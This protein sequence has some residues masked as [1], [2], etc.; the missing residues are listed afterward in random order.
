MEL[1]EFS[2]TILYGGR[3]R[4]P[5][6]G[7]VE[8]LGYQNTAVNLAT[9]PNAMLLHLPSLGV[10]SSQFIGVGR[11]GDVLSRMVDAVRP[12]AAAADMQWMDAGEIG[13]ASCRERV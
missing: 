9:G 13:R 1:A 5:T 4:H 12:V 7:V 2:G 11:H 6:H 8:V 3:R 10:K